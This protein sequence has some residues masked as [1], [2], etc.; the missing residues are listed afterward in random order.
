M[1][2]PNPYLWKNYKWL[3]A[4]PIALLLLSV[5]ILYLNASSNPNAIFGMT[6]GIDFK[7]GLLL[8]VYS[9]STPDAA[10]VKSAL[11]KYADSDV[12]PFNSPAGNGIEIEMPLNEGL[13]SAQDGLTTL[14]DLDNNLTQTEIAA[15]Y[16][17]GAIATNASLIPAAEANQ[18]NLDLL[19]G[20]VLAQ[21]AEVTRLAGSSASVGTDPHA[22]VTIAENAVNQASGSYREGLIAAVSAAMP[23]KS[24]SFKEIGSSL[25]KFFFTKVMDVILYSF[26]LS[27]IVVFAVFRSAVPSFAVLFGAAADISITAGAMTLFGVPLTLASF[28]ALLMLIGFSL[29]TDILLT[30]K[31]ITRKEGVPAERAFEAMH[32]G[33]MMNLSTIAAFGV[34]MLLAMMLQIPTYYQ[35]G[36]VAVIGA[37]AD[38]AATWCVNAV[39]VL[40]YVERKEAKHGAMA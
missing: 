4:L 22:A 39:M 23:V 12:R 2:L 31:V 6:P 17:A 19:K 15:G 40:W 34:L 35:I 9:D 30:T 3:V 36:A 18:K 13:K 25:S 20:E 1:E 10:A 21:A 24:Y 8:T 32:T 38:F 27:A 14:H 5:S 7:G 37:F 16:Y 11:S 29:D 26:L 33:F 28:A